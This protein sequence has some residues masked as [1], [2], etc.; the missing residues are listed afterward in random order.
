M[1][2]VEVHQVLVAAERLVAELLLRQSIEAFVGHD[3]IFADAASPVEVADGGLAAQVAPPLDDVG[4]MVDVVH[5]QIGLVGERL[6]RIEVVLLVLHPV[7]IHLPEHPLRRHLEEA[8]A[9]PRLTHRVGHDLRLEGMAQFVGQT[10][11]LTVLD[12]V[13]SHPESTYIVV[14]GAAVG[15]T[16]QRIHDHDHHLIMVGL[17]AR[18]RELQRVAEEMIESLYPILEVLQVEV[19]RV[20]LKRRRILEVVAE[21]AFPEKD[22]VV[23]LGRPLVAPLRGRIVQVH[24]PQV[25]GNVDFLLCHGMERQKKQNKGKRLSHCY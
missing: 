1:L 3:G 9:S 13:G 22:Q 6:E 23:G 20:A 16:L 2:E 25:L 19:H 4:R 5:G 7:G 17:R 21:S 8:G 10:V 15:C 24:A 12:A 11:Q 18:E 14:V